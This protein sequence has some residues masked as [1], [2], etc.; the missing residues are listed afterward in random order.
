MTRPLA[1]LRPQIH[2]RLGE[3]TAP[4]RVYAGLIGAYHS[5]GY[6]Q[7]TGAQLQYLVCLGDRPLACLRFGPAAWKLAS[8]DQYIGWSARARQQRLAW[9]ANND[10]FL[11]LPGVDVP[12]LASSVLAATL[13]QLRADWP[14]VYG[15]DL[16]L[17]ETFIEAQ[18]FSGTQEHFER[19]FVH[20]R[21]PLGVHY[22]VR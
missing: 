21:Q 16:A 18:R 12:H 9:V 5:L 13:C 3:D 1:Q 6:P 15:H 10:R 19:R 4:A 2:L 8:R 14:R 20:L 7:A 11:I 22:F 17:A